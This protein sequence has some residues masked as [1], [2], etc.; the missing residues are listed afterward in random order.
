MRTIPAF[1]V[2]SAGLTLA[3][4]EAE[5]QAAPGTLAKVHLAVVKAQAKKWR[6]DAV[7]FQIKANNVTDGKAMWEYDFMAPGGKQCLMAGVGTDGKAASA[8]MECGPISDEKEITSFAID[9]DQ[10]VTIARKAGLNKPKLTMGL[11]TSGSGTPGKL[12]W[13][14]MEDQGMKSGDQSVDIDAMTGA[15]TNQSKMP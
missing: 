8:E 11:M 13:L 5:G 10:A 1:L 9:S 12:V 2:A 4:A 14:V 15:V 3:S 7:L 6:P